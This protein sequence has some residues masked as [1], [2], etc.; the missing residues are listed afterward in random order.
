MRMSRVVLRGA[1]MHVALVVD[2]RHAGLEG[3]ASPG[4]PSGHG[5]GGGLEH[6][7]IA[8]HGGTSAWP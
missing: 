3:I 5:R 4:A 8:H 7:P 1:G 2:L 6:L